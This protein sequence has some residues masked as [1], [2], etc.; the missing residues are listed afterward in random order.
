MRSMYLIRVAAS[1][2]GCPKALNAGKPFASF[3]PAHR[4]GRG[5]SC[6]RQ[7][8]SIGTAIR[9]LSMDRKRGAGDNDEVVSVSSND[10]CIEDE[11]IF[12]KFIESLNA[13]LIGYLS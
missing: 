4:G 9:E 8:D 5:G 1:T 11:A 2:W 12:I 13:K 10:K 3:S 7:G 6:L